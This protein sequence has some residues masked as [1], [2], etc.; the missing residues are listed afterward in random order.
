MTLHDSHIG[1]QSIS[2][3]RNGIEKLPE[4]CETIGI[5]SR[6]T[7]IGERRKIVHR[8]HQHDVIRYK[9]DAPKTPERRQRT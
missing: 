4:R 3:D 1:E 2:F 6:S 8:L 9:K 5:F 7:H